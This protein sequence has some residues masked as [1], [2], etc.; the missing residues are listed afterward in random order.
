MPVYMVWMIE[1]DGIVMDARWVPREIQEIAY[2]KGFFP[3]MPEAKEE[4]APGRSG[5]S[6]NNDD[7]E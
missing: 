2:R 7:D 3:Y 6:A 1:I 5:N 4:K